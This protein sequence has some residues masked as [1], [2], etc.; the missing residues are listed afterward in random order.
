MCCVWGVVCVIVGSRHHCVVFG[1]VVCVIVGSRHNFGMMTHV[2]VL[3]FCSRSVF[4]AESG[5]NRK[6]PEN[7]AQAP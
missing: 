2:L 6:K 5:S 4:C 3:C 7:R 1:G